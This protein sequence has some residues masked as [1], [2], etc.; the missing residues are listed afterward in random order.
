MSKYITLPSRHL[1]ALAPPPS[2]RL[3]PPCDA[4]SC[5]SCSWQCSTETTVEYSSYGTLPDYPTSNEFFTTEEPS[6]DDDEDDTGDPDNTTQ[7][8]ALAIVAAS[9]S[10]L[11]VVIVLA[12]CLLTLWRRNRK[13][14]KVVTYEDV[15]MT[16]LEG[17]PKY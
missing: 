2:G 11:L 10:A 14:K 16:E 13:R 15:D 3:S 5:S 12:L 7:I 8:M 17:A 1:H 9:V 4:S 6:N